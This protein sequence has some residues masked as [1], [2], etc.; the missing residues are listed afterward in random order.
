[1]LDLDSPER[2]AIEARDQ[3]VALTGVR[4][5]VVVITSSTLSSKIEGGRPGRGS[6]T[7][8]SR[9]LSTNRRR[10]LLTVFGDTPRSAATREFIAPG[11]A[12]ASTI[13]DRRT[14]ARD[15]LRRLDQ[16]T[17][18][19]RST[20]LSN[21]S[22]FGRPVLAIHQLYDSPTNFRRMTLAVVGELQGQVEVAVLEQGDNVL[23]GVL[24]LRAHP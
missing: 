21:N 8:P 10:H 9:R 20:P 18:C 19:S 6:S 5:S 23:Q 16:R 14:N 11:T 7:Y 22:A 13:H 1:M 12:H 3:C 4:S 24:L 2:R 15:D 17:S